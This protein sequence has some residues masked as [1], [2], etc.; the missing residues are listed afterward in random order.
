V[1]AAEERLRPLQKRD[2]AAR[3]IRDGCYDS[4]DAFATFLDELPSGFTSAGGVSDRQDILGDL[5]EVARSE[6]QYLGRLRHLIQCSTELIPRWRADL[7][8]ILGENDVRM[9]LV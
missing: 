2:T 8:Q 7:T 3:R 9:K 1:S 6:R 5:R 4:V